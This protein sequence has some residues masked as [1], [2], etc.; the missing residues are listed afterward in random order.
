MKDR[1]IVLQPSLSVSL[2]INFIENP[3]VIADFLSEEISADAILGIRPEN[4][5]TV[6]GTDYAV[7]MIKNL[8]A[9]SIFMRKIIISILFSGRIE[10]LIIR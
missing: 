6:E 1:Q 3:E 7:N 10:I 4:L 8:E 9:S 2:K 5:Q